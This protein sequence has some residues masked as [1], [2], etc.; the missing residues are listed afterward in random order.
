MKRESVPC[1]RTKTRVVVT[2]TGYIARLILLL[3]T[4]VLGVV[5]PSLN[6]FAQQEMTRKTKKEVT[7]QFPPLARQLGLSGTVRVA[8]VISAEGKVKTA[9]AIG[10][11][12]LFMSAA[13]EAAKQWEFESNSKETTQVLEFQ[14]VRASK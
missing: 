11:P 2:S 10:G 3:L 14:F 12:P 7:P 13:E 5:T 1:W 9:H 4:V 6:L 8:V